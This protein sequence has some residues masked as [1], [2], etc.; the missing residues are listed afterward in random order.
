VNT[1]IDNTLRTS[2]KLLP[3]KALAL[4]LGIHYQT[5]YGWVREGSIPFTRVGARI[6]FDGSA[7]ADWLDRR[8]VGAR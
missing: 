2:A 3:L 5:L 6:K 1:T 8:R 4:T 7:V